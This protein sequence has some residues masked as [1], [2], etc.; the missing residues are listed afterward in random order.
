MDALM[1]QIGYG[2]GGG[3]F[4]MQQGRLPAAGPTRLACCPLAQPSSVTAGL[5]QLPQQP[6]PFLHSDSTI[7]T[8]PTRPRPTPSCA[9]SPADD[10]MGGQGVHAISAGAGMGR[11]GL[12]QEP[13]GDMG[14]GSA[15]L[16]Q[17]GSPNS[18]SVRPSSARRGRGGD[19]KVRRCRHAARRCCR[20]RGPRPRP[21]PCGSACSTSVPARRL[22]CAQWG[23]SRVPLLPARHMRPSP[24][25][26][27]PAATCARCRAAQGPDGGATSSGNGH[28][29][30]MGGGGRGS[31][32]K[33]VCQVDGCYADL[34]GLRDYHLRY[35]ICEYH[36]KASGRALA[37]WLAGWPHLRQRSGPRASL[38]IRGLTRGSCHRRLPRCLPGWRHTPGPC[39]CSARRSL[40]S[41]LPACPLPWPAGQQHHEGGQAAALLPAV[42][43]L[44]SPQRL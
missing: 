19:D 14:F 41:R 40:P 5:A 16:R 38:R 15:V 10:D 29:V 31:L 6:P 30:T 44:P 34:T 2:G 35:K 24:L 1:Q 21:A 13:L 17:G 39:V 37:G 8:A 3:G 25:A 18:N 36:L 43:P 42:R 26:E 27:A 28:M 4:V 32:T 33:G 23:A 12:L 7:V 9:A 11:G 22:C 20:G